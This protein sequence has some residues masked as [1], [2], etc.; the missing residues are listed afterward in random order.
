[1]K[2]ILFSA[3]MVKALLNTKPN[4]WPP[5]P[6]DPAK[7]CKWQTRRVITRIGGFGP[8]T[9]F[10]ESATPGYK[11]HFRDK[12]LRWND[13]REIKPLWPPGNI[14]WVRETWGITGYNNWGGHFICVEHKTDGKPR[15]IDLDDEALWERCV[16]QEVK[17]QENHDDDAIKWRSPLFMPRDAARIKLEVKGVRIERLRDI[18]E[19]EA[20]AEGVNGCCANRHCDNPDECAVTDYLDPFMETWDSLNAKR[21]CGW[22]SNPWVWVYEFMRIT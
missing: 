20:K 12:H 13:V 1:M 8:I 2:P 11:Y 21:G 6:I 5:E 4:T 22:V 14:L 3:P 17:W 9:E 7:P 15:D 10:G 16:D 19:D 18:T